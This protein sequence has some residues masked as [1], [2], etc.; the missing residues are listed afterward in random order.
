MGVYVKKALVLGAGGFIGS[1]MVK[2][3]KK[4]GYWVRG[5]DLKS[6]EYSKTEAD[7]F[8]YGDLR[9]PS[10][11]KRVLEY[12]GDRGNFYNSVPYR[13]IHAFDEIYQFAA[14]M[15]GAGFVFTGENDAEIMQNSVT[16]N[17][18]VLEQQ[19]LLDETFDGKQGWSECN[20]PVLDYRTKI[21]YS[22][23]ACMYPEHNQLDPNDP[24]CREDS[25]YPA[26]PDSEY[27]WEK[28]FSERLYLAYNRNHGIPVR[29]ARYH[30]IFGPEGTWD[31][32]RE[33]APAAIC[34]KVALLKEQSGSIEVWGDGL[35]TRSFLFIDECIEATRRLMDSDFLG[36]VNIGSE[37]MVTINQLVDTAAKVA[38]KTVEKIY[39]DGPLGVRGRNSNNDL[40]REKL[41]WDYSQTLEEGIAKTYS[42]I[43]EQIN[44]SSI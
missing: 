4:D 35:Q 31:G 41:G 21:F 2:R 8:V 40:V 28:L 5:V 19:R 29:I 30:N 44:D 22:G 39:I 38:G 6:P 3:L 33:K 7:E 32:G 12:K 26:A 13:Y 37:E 24:N 17:L 16:I 10:F 11:V 9:D 15:G 1:H 42:W 43:S 14:D 27:G 25:A 20:R 36:P 23:S 34:R 18:N